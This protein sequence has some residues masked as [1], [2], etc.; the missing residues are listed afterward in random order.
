MAIAK[1]VKYAEMVCLMHLDCPALTN[2]KVES[3]DKSSVHTT[4]GGCVELDI[5]THPD[6]DNSGFL[7]L[8]IDFWVKEQVTGYCQS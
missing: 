5:P 1:S 6:Y 7:Y 8:P 3:Q 4:F 2:V